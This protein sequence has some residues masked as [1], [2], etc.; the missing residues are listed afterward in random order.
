MVPTPS[1]LLDSTSISFNSH[2]LISYIM[3]LTSY[4]DE[5][6]QIILLVLL[7]LCPLESFNDTSV[8]EN[9]PYMTVIRHIILPEVVSLLIHQDLRISIPDA[10]N[11]LRESQSFGAIMHPC[12]KESSYFLS[13]LKNTTSDDTE[14]KKMW[15]KY[16]LWIKAN[17]AMDFF[18]WLD[19]QSCL[20]Q[21]KKADKLSLQLD[22]QSILSKS[23]SKSNNQDTHPC[24]ESDDDPSSP[25][26][27]PDSPK[28][29]SHFP[30]H[31]PLISQAGP[32][33]ANSIKQEPNDDRLAKI[34][35][36]GATSSSSTFIDL[37]LDSDSDMD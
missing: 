4:G 22:K 3:F 24:A 28:D 27:F 20:K 8:L 29:L 16:G 33:R 1:A 18:E 13:I 17:T 11:V 23:V 36:P 12:F 19:L 14:Y 21:N 25:L 15:L 7:S 30:L 2:A 26:S 35:L 32:A 9:L 34:S 31:Q 5:G 10:V 6:Y 37:T